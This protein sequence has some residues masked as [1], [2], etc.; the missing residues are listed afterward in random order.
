M[1]FKSQF[2]KNYEKYVYEARK[3]Y[4]ENITIYNKGYSIKNLIVYLPIIVAVIG[5]FFALLNGFDI[6]GMII[7]FVVVVVLNIAIKIMEKLFKLNNLSN[8]ENAIRRLGF[9]SI[10]S[11]EKALKLYVTGRFG[12]YT[13]LLNNYK[14]QYGLNEKSKVIVD[15]NGFPFYIFTDSKMDKIILLPANTNLKPK[16]DII[17]YGSIR[18]YRVDTFKQMIVLKTNNDEYF[19]KMN[20]LQVFN[21]LIKEKEYK[22]LGSFNPAEYI[23]DFEL[24]MHKKKREIKDKLYI[25]NSISFTALIQA[26][27]CVGVIAVSFII[28]K[29]TG[30]YETILVIARLISIFLIAIFT[31]TFIHYFSGIVYGEDDYIRIINNDPKIIERF[32]ELKLALNIRNDYDTIY[33]LEGAPYLTWYCNGYFHLFL[34]AIYFDVVY[35]VINP[36]TIQYFKVEGNECIIKMDNSVLA[37][38]SNA[39]RVLGKVIPNKDYDWLHRIE[40]N[41]R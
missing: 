34:N 13:K 14:Q 38:K 7:A 21:E 4:Y 26:A 12:Y 6:K 1:L 25:D 27:V 37:F 41:R 16:L 20:A 5:V 18:Y 17:K 30:G 9:F 2:I 10:E 35:M 22:N 3:E 36:K 8:Y 39:K 24:F 15:I 33:S 31:N 40:K 32:N 29:H 23:S 28:E 19:F 11:Y